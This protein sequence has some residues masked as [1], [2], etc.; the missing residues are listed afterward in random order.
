[1]GYDTNTNPPP[2][3]FAGRVFMLEA[4]KC[5]ARKKAE[6][7]LWFYHLADLYEARINVIRAMRAA[8]GC[9]PVPA[10]KQQG[11][12]ED[13]SSRMS[14]AGYSK[15]TAALA[16]NFKTRFGGTGQYGVPN[17]T[18]TNKKTGEQADAT[19]ASSPLFQSLLELAY[20]ER[21]AHFKILARC[22][23]D[24]FFEEVYLPNKQYDMFY[25]HLAENMSDEE[26][27]DYVIRKGFAATRAEAAEKFPDR[28]GPKDSPLQQCFR[29]DTIAHYKQVH[30][31]SFFSFEETASIR[32]AFSD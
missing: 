21:L 12:A 30:D 27:H 23:R 11:Q 16:T 2:I 19:N 4:R 25:Y 22:V 14:P 9:P 1:M 13:I 7:P 28:Y 32:H 26:F 3:W 29:N 31:E 15:L 10:S 18:I 8:L 6:D 17:Y 20:T 24:L 5:L